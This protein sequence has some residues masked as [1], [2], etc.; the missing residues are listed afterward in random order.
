MAH[1][2]ARSRL[3]GLSL[4]RIYYEALADIAHPTIKHLV[5]VVRMSVGARY[6]RR[7]LLCIQC[8]EVNTRHQVVFHHILQFSSSQLLT[9]ARASRH[10]RITKPHPLVNLEALCHD[11]V[12]VQVRQLILKDLVVN[13]AANFVDAIARLFISHH[14]SETARHR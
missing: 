1:A 3:V 2:A 7:T 5:K 6:D 11:A 10:R 9:S 13:N 4:V 14:V 8:L 12:Q